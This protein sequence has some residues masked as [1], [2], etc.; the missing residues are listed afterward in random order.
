MTSFDTDPY[1]A[2]EEMDEVLRAIVDY[3]KQHPE[4]STAQIRVNRALAGAK[5][6]STPGIMHNTRMKVARENGGAWAITARSEPTPRGLSSLIS[7]GF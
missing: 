4:I 5:E 2:D 3:L 7:G 1:L 6:S